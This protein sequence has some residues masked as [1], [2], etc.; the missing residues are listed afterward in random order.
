MVA[1]GDIEEL[2]AIGPW[3]LRSCWA[4]TVPEDRY[5]VSSA[6]VSGSLPLLASRPAPTLRATSDGTG[7]RR[8]WFGQACVG[9]VAGL[10]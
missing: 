5:G 1:S 10:R 4:S 8:V 7:A 2:D 6:S 9:T 3:E